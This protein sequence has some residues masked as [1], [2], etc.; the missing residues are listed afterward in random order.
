MVS[1]TIVAL[2]ALVLFTSL[3]MAIRAWNQGSNRVSASVRTRIGSDLIRKQL[4]CLSQVTTPVELPGGLRGQPIP[5]F[6]GDNRRVEF[7][8]LSALRFQENPGLTLVSYYMDNQ[9]GRQC[10]VE[11]ERPF[12]G[13]D[14]WQQKFVP[15]NPIA[16]AE[17]VDDIQLRY[18][19]KIEDPPASGNIIRNWVDMWDSEARN[20]LPQAIELS[21]K[22]P[23]LNGPS[24]LATAPT[25]LRIM[26][27]IIT[28]PIN[29]FIGR[30]PLGPGNPGGPNSQRFSPS[31]LGTGGVRG[32]GGR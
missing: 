4:G 28:K 19:E 11:T 20:E 23:R 27:P 6:K 10:L 31:R 32:Q 14:T 21:V 25:D 3:N 5:F 16:L 30:R 12:V 2:V 18:L 24:H 17:D 7:V 29:F 9:G 22:L 13:P 26:V 1:L 8:T 15:P